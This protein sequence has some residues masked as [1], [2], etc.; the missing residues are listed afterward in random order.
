MEKRGRKQ[1]KNKKKTRRCFEGPLQLQR[2]IEFEERTAWRKR[3]TDVNQ[4][5][6][7]SFFPQ[8]LCLILCKVHTGKLRQK[9]AF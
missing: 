3:N 1:N 7:S 5:Y 4:H 2:Q 8:G 6:M 9:I